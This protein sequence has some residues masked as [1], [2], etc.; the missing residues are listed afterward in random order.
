MILV[1]IRDSLV[2]PGLNIRLVRVDA[3]SF[4]IETGEAPRVVFRRGQREV[5]SL[6]ESEYLGH[7][8]LE[9]DGY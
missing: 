9:G 4:S 2:G 1:K 3:D 6:P 5:Y 8:D 7:L